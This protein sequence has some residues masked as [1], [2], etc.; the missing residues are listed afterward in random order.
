M[1]MEE[2]NSFNGTESHFSRVLILANILHPLRILLCKNSQPTTKS[3]AL[4]VGQSF[5]HQVSFKG[6]KRA[7]GIVFQDL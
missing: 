4:I 2:E 3:N 6:M 7:R 5:C 1:R